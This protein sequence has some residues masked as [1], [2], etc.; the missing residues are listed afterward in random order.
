MPLGRTGRRWRH[1]IK[2]IFK[3]W[4]GRMDWIDLAQDKGKWWAVVNSRMNIRLP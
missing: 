2:L 3:K 4:N 1:N